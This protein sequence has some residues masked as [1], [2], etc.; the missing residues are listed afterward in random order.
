MLFDVAVLGLGSP[1]AA[2]ISVVVNHS[3]AGRRSRFR[4]SAC[5]C[6]S[7]RC[8]VSY[9]KWTRGIEVQLFNVRWID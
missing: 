1:R 9:V 7:G 2:D 6:L 4:L 8:V 3:E 5:V